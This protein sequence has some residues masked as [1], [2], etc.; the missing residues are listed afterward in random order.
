MKV[1]T[2]VKKITKSQF[3][4]LMVKETD[5]AIERLTKCGL[6]VRSL[7]WFLN[8]ERENSKEAPCIYQLD[9]GLALPCPI[10]YQC[11]K[12]EPLPAWFR[13]Y[14]KIT[15][16]HHASDVPCW[17]I[18]LKTKIRCYAHDEETGDYFYS[19]HTPGKCPHKSI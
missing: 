4:S 14:V 9:S 15:F 12:K 11:I 3:D 2:K 5:L 17:K 7:R 16:I 6:A 8:F 1:K 19:E 10:T 18:N 13:K